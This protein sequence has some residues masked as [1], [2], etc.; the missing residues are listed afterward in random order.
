MAVGAYVLRM[1]S[2]Y[3]CAPWAD[4]CRRGSQLFGF[5][6]T[7]IFLGLLVVM[8]MT[9]RRSWERIAFVGKALLQLAGGGEA[10]AAVAS[11]LAPDARPRPGSVAAAGAA[12]SRGGSG[13]AA[14]GS[15]SAAADAADAAAG[16]GA[17][18]RQRRRGGQA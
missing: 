16:A 18:V 7:V 6:Y 17:G 14:A 5:V 3:T 9:G 11:M 10:G 4:V 13:A 12:H 1:I 2:D 8:Y 15:A